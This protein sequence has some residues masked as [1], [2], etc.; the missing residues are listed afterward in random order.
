MAPIPAP[1]APS[2]AAPGPAVPGPS[3]RR[4]LLAVA[5]VALVLGLVPTPAEA[6]PFGPPPRSW[7]EVDG[8]TVL[9]SW[10][11]AY[12]DY[13]ALGEQLGYFE[14]GTSAAYLDPSVQ[15]APP[16]SDEQ[17]LTDSDELRTYLAANLVVAQDGEPC[18]LDLIHTERFVERGA[19]VRHQCPQPVE[20]LTLRIT[21]LQEINEAYRTFGLAEEGPPGPFAVFTH[22]QP[23]HRIDVTDL[24]DDGGDGG[25][26]VLVGAL[27]VLAVGV[28]TAV[29][30]LTRPDGA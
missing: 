4:L 19:I 15:V 6:H 29:R 30:R 3:A 17:A 12:D 14:P 13:L 28:P 22:E 5:L 9:L 24:T 2:P 1:P 26:L 27:A 8:T 18:D 16:R 7:L 23:E 25:R 11:A 10:E 20:E 21:M